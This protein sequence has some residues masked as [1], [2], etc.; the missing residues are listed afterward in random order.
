MDLRKTARTPRKALTPAEKTNRDAKYRKTPQQFGQILE[1]LAKIFE[2]LMDLNTALSSAGSGGYLGFPNTNDP[3][4]P[5]IP[6]RRS[7]LRSAKVQFKNALKELNSYFRISIK[8]P[9]TPTKPESFR[10]V[11]TPVYA[12]D[13]LNA[14]IN[15]DGGVGFGVL[16]PSANANDPVA[17]GG[18]L[19]DQ[20]PLVKQGYFLRNTC[21][22]LFYIY[23]RQNSLQ[24]TQEGDGKHNGQDSLSDDR[25]N[26]AFDDRRI[27]AAFWAERIYVGKGRNKKGA[28]SDKYATNKMLMQDAV[29][30]GKAA[31]P[32]TTYEVIESMYPFTAGGD[33]VFDPRNKTG[34]N[35]G[36]YFKNFFFQNIASLNQFN[37]ARLQSIPSLAAASTEIDKADTR[38]NM[39]NE[40]NIVKN[41]S[42]EW[43][44]L[45][46]PS[47]KATRDAKTKTRPKK[48]KATKA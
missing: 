3:N 30:Q 41:A 29:D 42:L 31:V 11:F 10:G 46:A 9:R 47:L 37:R 24:A 16:H 14:F 34:L 26:A 17:L 23:A 27:P 25:M 43:G 44:I 28:E 12:A 15:A 36:G 5:L 33:K 38:A 39:L 1:N 48:A 13:A 35:P 20:L 22:M 21:T 8:K 2:V 19:M 32:M 4:G 45:L 18:A 40:H 6:F 7:H